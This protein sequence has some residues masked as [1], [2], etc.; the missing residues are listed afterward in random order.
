MSCW[1]GWRTDGDVEFDSGG[2][3]VGVLVEW[4][5][6][7]YVDFIIDGTLC[8]VKEPSNIIL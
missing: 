1:V 4:C 7:Y 5:Y 3:K 8:N 2:D 6:N